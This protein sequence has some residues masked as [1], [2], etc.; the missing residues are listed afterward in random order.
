MSDLN[1]LVILLYMLI[2]TISFHVSRSWGCSYPET[3]FR[4]SISPLL[5][6]YSIVEIIIW[7]TRRYSKRNK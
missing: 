2:F 4:A 1:I 6:L 7:R 3:I 5:V